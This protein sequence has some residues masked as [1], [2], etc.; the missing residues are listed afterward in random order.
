MNKIQTSKVEVDQSVRVEELKR[1]TILAVAN[2]EFQYATRFP[3]HLK[4]QLYELFRLSGMRKKF[5]PW[6]FAVA[7]AKLL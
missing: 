1:D 3:V 5:G 2:K 4:R 7:V 6:V